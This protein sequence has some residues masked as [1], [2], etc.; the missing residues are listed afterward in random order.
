MLHKRAEMKHTAS[1]VFALVLFQV[2]HGEAIFGG[3]FPNNGGDPNAFDL[4]NVLDCAADNGG[5]LNVPLVP[6]SN[7]SDHEYWLP[8]ESE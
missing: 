1:L 3:T 2:H 6:P 4:T 7:A 5:R 8:Q